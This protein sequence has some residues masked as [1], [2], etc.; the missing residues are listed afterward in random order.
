MNFKRG[1]SG[2]LKYGRHRHHESCRIRRFTLHGDNL[3]LTELAASQNSST[4][5]LGVP[6]NLSASAPRV[7]LGFAESGTSN[8]NSDCVRF[9]ASDATRSEAL[10]ATSENKLQTQNQRTLG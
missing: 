2:C 10:K 8:L 7:S 5:P 1:L 4:E 9:G 3:R 6:M